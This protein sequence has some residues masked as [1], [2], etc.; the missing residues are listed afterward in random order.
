MSANGGA[1]GACVSLVEVVKA[2]H[3]IH[4]FVMLLLHNLIV[5]LLRLFRGYPTLFWLV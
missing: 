4:A 2:L 5:F 3:V 1:F